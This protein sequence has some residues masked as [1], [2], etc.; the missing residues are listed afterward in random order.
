MRKTVLTLVALGLM[1]VA[2]Q[3]AAVGAGSTASSSGQIRFLGGARCALG[4]AFRGFP[5][6]TMGKLEWT[7]NGVTHSGVF[8]VPSPGHYYQGLGRFLGMPQDPVTV[9]FKI[10]AQGM[11]HVLT[12]TVVLNCNC[13]PGGGGSGGG[14]NENGGGTPSAGAASAVSSTPGFAG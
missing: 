14:G 2:Y 9:D 12:G 5:E 10:A 4:F 7:A 1:V 11:S 6:G 8:Q 3:G 13:Q